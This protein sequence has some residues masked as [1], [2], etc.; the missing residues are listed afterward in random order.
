MKSS[1]KDNTE[2]KMHKVKGKIKETA[3]K[4][5]GNLDL[6]AEGKVEKFEGEAQEKLGQIKKVL[7]K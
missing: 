5:V 1:T 4:A 7:D 2:G 3:G 6:E